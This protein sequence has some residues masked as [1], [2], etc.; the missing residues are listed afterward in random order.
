MARNRRAAA[1]SSTRRARDPSGISP[2]IIPET[3]S[4]TSHLGHDLQSTVAEASGVRA[5]F[6]V[7][8]SGRSRRAR[9]QR[10]SP[11]PL[12]RSTRRSRRA[13]RNRAE[14]AAALA[15]GWWHEAPGAHGLE[16]QTRMRRSGAAG[17]SVVI[18]SSN[19]RPSG[20]GLPSGA[21][22]KAA[23]TAVPESS[24]MS[25]QPIVARPRRSGSSTVPV[26]A[27]TPRRP[28]PRAVP[29]RP[30]GAGQPG[31]GGAARPRHPGVRVSRHSSRG[32]VPAR[33]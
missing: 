30:P 12:P 20:R 19:A 29:S 17:A 14:R 18:R 32:G 4:R 25:G 2:A 1:T 7:R 23:R 3:Y 24:T 11:R 8:S 13:G 31:P 9:R 26:F 10:D 28:T 22:L 27:Q 21:G 5:A 33:S 16:E 6:T 15:Q